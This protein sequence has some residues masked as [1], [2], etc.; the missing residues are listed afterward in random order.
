MNC[1]IHRLYSRSGLNSDQALDDISF[2]NFLRW[3]VG[4]DCSKSSGKITYFSPYYNGF[5]LLSRKKY[6]C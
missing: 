2:Q 4:A 6:R 3:I 5:A 1:Q